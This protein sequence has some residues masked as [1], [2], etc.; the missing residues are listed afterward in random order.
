VS[1]RA[2]VVACSLCA[3]VARKSLQQP[4]VEEEHA[5]KWIVLALSGTAAFMT[6]LDA[7][8]VNISL[9][10]MAAAFGVTL[11]GG[12]EWVLIAYLLAIAA[13]LM[14]LG[15]LADMI[16]RK[17]IFLIG[18]GI[19]GLGSA[20]CG[21]APGLGFL[22][23]ARVLQG[24]GA[25]CI[26]AVNMAMITQSFPAS[27]RG[28]AFGINAI[29]V[30]L[31][32]STG[33]TLGGIITEYL[34]WRWIFYVNVPIA[35]AAICVASR[36]LTERASL[37]P[38]SFDVVGAAL[39]GWWIDARDTGAVVWTGMG[40]DVAIDCGVTRRRRPAAHPGVVCGEARGVSN[41]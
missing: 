2:V 18:L 22:I 16:G 21:A 5:N 7:S 20:A 30:A 26:F 25:A 9:P 23:G 3:Q 8:V 37:R 17:P 14:S 27:E 15:R 12:I 32:V 39:L 11:T 40:V 34:T 35:L 6:T 31:G 19:F 4:E 13:V 10:S 1:D 24:V 38:Q 36:V 28:R 33:P 29:L 41:N